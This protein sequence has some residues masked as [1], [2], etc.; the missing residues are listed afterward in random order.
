MA[1]SSLDLDVHFLSELLYKLSLKETFTL[2]R[3]C[4]HDGLKEGLKLE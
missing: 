1:F 3:L 2:V 4:C